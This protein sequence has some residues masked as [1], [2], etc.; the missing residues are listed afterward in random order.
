MRLTTFGFE[1]EYETNAFAVIERMYAAD[2][3]G[4]SS[5]HSYHCDCEFCE[6]GGGYAFRGQTDSSCSGEVISD[7][8]GPGTEYDHVGLMRELASA[9]VDVDA[10]PGLRSAFHVHVGISALGLHDKREALWQFIRWEPVLT[11]LAG[12]RWQDQRSGMNTS[13]RDCTTHAHQSAV[14]HPYSVEDF[15]GD[16]PSSDTLEFLLQHQMHTDRHSNLNIAARRQPTWEFRLWN[17]TRSAWRMEMFAGVSV[18][19]VDPRV[20][21]ALEA[22]HPPQR[23]H[24]PSSGIESIATA[25]D[26]AG[27][28]RIAELVTRQADYLDTKAESAPSVLTAL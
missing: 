9:S 27:H 28:H 23:R 17:S 14:G 6:F 25:I 22:L 1:A 8:M 2:L 15:Q 7:I 16:T 10:E 12:G 20:V 18:A 11:R 4:T 13:V 5:L 3:A 26:G 21:R 24:R 19:L